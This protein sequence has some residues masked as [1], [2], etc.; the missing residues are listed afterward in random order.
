MNVAVVVA[1]VQAEASQGVRY[2]DCRMFRNGT[3]CLQLVP[4]TELALSAIDE[5]ERNAGIVGNVDPPANGKIFAV[6]AGGDVPHSGH[7]KSPFA[8]VDLA[9]ADR[10]GKMAAGENG[11]AAVHS[12]R[13]KN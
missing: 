10:S 1:A 12:A 5:L 7:D 6:P 4:K 9:I 2:V 13:L 8:V 11:R 3:C